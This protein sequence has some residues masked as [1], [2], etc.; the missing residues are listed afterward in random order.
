MPKCIPSGVATLHFSEPVSYTHLDV[1][2][3]QEPISPGEVS[4]S[5]PGETSEIL[6]NYLESVIKKNNLVQKVVGF[7][8]DNCNTNFGGVKRKGVNNVYVRLKKELAR[9]IVGI[10]CGAHIVHTCLQTAVDVLPIEVE[11]LVVKI[12]KYFYIYTVRVTE[13]KSSA[14]LYTLSTKT[15]YN[16][17]PPCSFP[18]SSY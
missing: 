9:N 10:G 14:T 5:V 18:A 8:G 17:I 4:E 11:A 6:A 13:L 7:C 1:Y 12:Y 2:K 15:F 3:R 16:M